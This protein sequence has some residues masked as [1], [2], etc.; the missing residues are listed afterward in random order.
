MNL[1]QLQAFKE[2]MLTGS[3]T[4]AARNIGRTQPAIST[5][6]AGLESSVGYD[7][8]ER[9]GGG[10]KGHGIVAQYGRDDQDGRGPI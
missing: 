6:I 9:R 5:L 4:E 8:F 10:E 7:L 2:V 1:R 3:V